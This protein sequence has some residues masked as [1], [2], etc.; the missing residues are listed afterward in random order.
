MFH[1]EKTME[2]TQREQLPGTV[3]NSAG[4]YSFEAN[5]WTRLDR[6]LIIGTEA[7]TYY[8]TARELSR[9]NA[10]ATLQCISEDGPRVVARIVE[11]SDSGR[12][13]KNDP[14]LFALALCAKHPDPK[15]RAAAFVALPKV[16]RIATHLFHFAE[17][18]KAL[19]GWG[20]GT[21]RA[22]ANWYR[23][24]AD[25]RLVLQ[26]I[27][28]QQRDGWSHR[29]VLRKAHPVPVSDRQ[30]TI[31]HW[32]T[33]GWES[34]GDTPHDDPVLA[35]IWAFERGKHLLAADESKDLTKREA[36][37][38]MVK[39]ISDYALPHECVPNDLKSSP[40][41]WEAML[42]SMGLGALVRN[43][44]KMTNVGLLSTLSKAT[45]FVCERLGDVDAIR[46][47]RLHPMSLLVALKVYEQ[48]HG[49]KGSLSWTPN[50]RIVDALDAA[51]Y[52]AFKAVEPT[53]KR[54][55]LALDVSSSMTGPY[56]GG[57]P[58]ITPRVASA[59][60]SL[61][62]AN[63]EPQHAF[64]AF[65]SGIIPISI[66]PSWRLAEAVRYLDGFP[67]GGTDCAAPMVYA[68]EHKIPVDEFVIYTDNE[69]WFGDIHPCRALQQYRQKM[70][71]PAK[72]VTVGM[73]GNKST[74]ADPN[75]SGMLDVVGFDTDT[76]AL[77][78]DFVR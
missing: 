54:F 69:T 34:V 68:T 56:I 75:D 78:S 3:P 61:V 40:Q 30:K 14:A 29:D 2:P 8:A 64:T 76:P 11:V 17:Y 10:H 53:G 36:V 39:L 19:G 35:Q 27:K 33:H 57:M 4:G 66:S 70:G 18:I 67:F 72:L 47:A 28:Y 15:T 65:T 26:A 51:F 16:V 49:D 21:K 22:F 13:P 31:F 38:E 46:Q 60:M 73:I 43:L 59:A 45:A 44:G 50:R 62:T 9:E 71:I 24:M 41:I 42:P 25:D 77:V 52:L 5:I 6:F 23:N 55:M 7:D 58:G 74:I 12:A 1:Y 63:V 20:T 48:G 32:M 37:R